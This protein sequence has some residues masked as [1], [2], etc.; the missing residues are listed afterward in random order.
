MADINELLES[1]DIVDYIGKYVD[2]EQ[3]GD[4]WWGLSCF[5]NEEDPSFS[6]RQDPPVW[7]DYSSGKSGGVL[8]FTK[9]YHNC[10]GS[11]AVE[12]LK[13]YAGVT[14]ELSEPA[15][16]MQAVLTCKKY[17]P[18]K[19][20][21]KQP[22][23]KVLPENCMEKYELRPDKLQVWLDE[24][25]SEES[26]KKF[27]VYYDGFSDRLVYPIRNPDGKIVNIGGR[28]L[29]PDWR[30]KGLRK[31]TYFYSWG[32]IQTLYGLSENMDAI[33]ERRE[34]LIFEGC[35]SVLLADTWGIH[36]SAALLT[37]HLGINQMKLLA[38][39]G[40]RVVF[41]LDKGI[42]IRDDKNIRRL[43]NYIN[44]EYLWD[45]DN[46]LRDKDSP[47][48]NGEEVFRKLYELSA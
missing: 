13:Q 7:Y 28:T 24:G 1:I 23:S 35:K 17:V 44:V 40:V 45:R 6:V 33:R 15:E 11:Q 22:T 4:E 16:K 2:L 19:R 20:A 39:L 38:K 34:L 46:L 42:L 9:L 36:N 29:D 27:Q 30:A 47:V 3:R 12:I 26:L 32:T 5:T 21:A 48:D 8:S 10:S 31:Y 43:K 37:S 41:A 18:P 25:V 14:G